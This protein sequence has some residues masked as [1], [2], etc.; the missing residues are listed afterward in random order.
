MDFIFDVP[1]A[2]AAEI[3]GY[4]HDRETPGLEEH[5]FYELTRLT[6]PTGAKRAWWRFW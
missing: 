6:A 2:L 1:V 3:V 5:G 4:R